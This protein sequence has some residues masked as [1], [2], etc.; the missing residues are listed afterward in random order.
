MFVSGNLFRQDRL[1]STLV[2]YLSL[3]TNVR[4]N[5]EQLSVTITR[6]RSSL[7]RISVEMLKVF[8]VE[9]S[10]EGRLPGADSAD[11]RVVGL[12]K[13]GWPGFWSGG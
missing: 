6:K 12:R 9:C 4:P 11:S 8:M 13:C 5:G 1:E 10:Q 2:G 7:L 3:K